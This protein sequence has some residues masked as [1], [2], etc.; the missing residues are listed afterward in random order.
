MAD[1]T[2]T[3]WEANRALALGLLAAFPSPWLPLLENQGALC[4]RGV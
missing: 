2:G 4:L 3:I 1:G